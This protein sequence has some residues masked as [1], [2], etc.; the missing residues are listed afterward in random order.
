MDLESTML[1]EISQAVKDKYHMISPRSGT[2]SI[3]QTSMQ[4]I[5]RDTET[6]NK[7]TVTRG[8]EGGSRGKKGKGCQGT[9]MKGPWMKTTVGE[10]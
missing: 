1:N 10:D 8:E 3:K 9:C 2:Y 6:K 7:L 4:N 5:T